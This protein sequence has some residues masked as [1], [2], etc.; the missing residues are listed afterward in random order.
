[1]VQL[2]VNNK[3]NS[4]LTFLCFFKQGTVDINFKHLFG[5]FKIRMS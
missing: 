4:S 3:N 2:I 1:M 5:N